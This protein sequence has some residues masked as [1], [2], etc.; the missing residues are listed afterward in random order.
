M[1]DES[2]DEYVEQIRGADEVARRCIVLYAVLAA[3][4]GE[5]R[6]ELVAWLRREGL[7]G[8]VS[9]KESE[10]LLSGCPTQRQ[11]I[12]ATWRAEALLP[13][14][15]SLR[16]VSELPIP[17]Q[18]CDVQLIRR[19]LPQL[20]GS[21]GEFISTARLRSDSEIHDANEEIYQIHWRVRDAQLRNQP[22]PPGKLPR[23]P[24]EDCEPPARSYN[25]GVVQERH[26]A[27]NWLIGYCEQDWDDIK[28]D[29]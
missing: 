11:R 5:P 2:Q 6:D 26:H 8:A 20:L 23:M 29:T 17:Q 21:V 9:S 25:A 13:L 15:W 16:L 4:N 27:L 3:G 22:T 1:P 7:W 14:L 24:V 12:N 19:V 18:L 28:T 10:F